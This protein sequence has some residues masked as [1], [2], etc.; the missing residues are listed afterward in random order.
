MT[1]SAF[2]CLLFC[3]HECFFSSSDNIFH[4]SVHYVCYTM[5]V[6]CFELQGRGFTNFHCYCYGKEVDLSFRVGT[7]L[8]LRVLCLPVVAALCR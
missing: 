8:K 4:L 7:G 5:I 3:I 2:A 1:C 6:Q